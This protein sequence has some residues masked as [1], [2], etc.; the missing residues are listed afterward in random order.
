MNDPSVDDQSSVAESANTVSS[1]PAIESGTSRERHPGLW[2]V[3][4][5]VSAALAALSI[6]YAPRFFQLPEEFRS[7][8]PTHP[9]EMQ[10]EAKAMTKQNTWWNTLVAY[11]LAGALFSLCSLFVAPW[12]SPGRASLAVVG[13]LAVGI[14]GGALVAIVG[15]AV[16]EHLDAGF[17]GLNELPIVADLIT[18]MVVSIL[19]AL[20][21]AAALLISGKKSP[22]Q[23]AIMI[24]VAGVIMGLLFPVI[25]SL[26]L[27]N[28]N[29]AEFPPY[30]S[31]MIG[32]WM[33]LLAVTLWV[34]TT[35]T[36]TESPKQTHASEATEEP[37]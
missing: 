34:L 24:P 36:G 26:L 8:G 12:R 21:V 10:Q 13:C 4:L 18:W 17:L 27:P 5:L 22:T 30:D 32:A 31:S 33:L 28:A 2:A 15:F 29:T 14:V 20:P 25:V 9:A 11:T 1:K 6:N 16:R 19:M 35:F 23:E 3:A 37:T 7:V